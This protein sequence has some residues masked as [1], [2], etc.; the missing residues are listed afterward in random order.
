MF[1]HAFDCQRRENGTCFITEDLVEGATGVY[2]SVHAGQPQAQEAVVDA[3]HQQDLAQ[4]Q[5]RVPDVAAEVGHGGLT[6]GQPASGVPRC[7]PSSRTR[8][9]R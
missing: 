2:E 8:G 6:R 5:H 9:R 4:D 3:L 7:G 1:T